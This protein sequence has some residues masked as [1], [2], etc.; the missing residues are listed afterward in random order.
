MNIL[1]IVAHPDDET[2]AM[3]G[4][5]AQHAHAGD[6]VTVVTCTDGVSSRGRNPAAARARA[7][8]F[9][10]ACAALGVG[11]CHMR[12]VFEDQRSDQVPQLVL[13]QAVAA[14]VDRP[15]RVYTHDPC[16]LNLDH[17][18]VAEAVLVATRG[19]C[20]VWSAKPEWPDRA[21]WPF[22][23]TKI[24]DIT[25]GLPMKQAACRAYVDEW[26]DPPHPRAR[27]MTVTE[28]YFIERL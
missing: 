15:D 10:T 9:Q 4:T 6:R 28:E 22:R 3:G 8:H 1:V 12:A 5:L 7:T 24:V 19:V 26:R 2:F 14:F 17:R 27:A 13:N 18:R 21:L 11:G 16:D 20:P 25:E 23:P